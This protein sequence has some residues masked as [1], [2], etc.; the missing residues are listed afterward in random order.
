[1]SKTLLDL[2]EIHN[3][4]I[5]LK[6]IAECIESEGDSFMTEDVIQ[7][8]NSTLDYLKTEFRKVSQGK[9]HEELH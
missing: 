2:H 8:M 3:C 4:L 6:S 7:D 9:T 1:M 5:R